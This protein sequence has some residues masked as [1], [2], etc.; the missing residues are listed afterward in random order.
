VTTVRPCGDS[1]A[2]T[3]VEVEINRGR[4]VDEKEKIMGMSHAH[5]FLAINFL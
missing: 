4:D 3:K 5:Y 2:T 1:G